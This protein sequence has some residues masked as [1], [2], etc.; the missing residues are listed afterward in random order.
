MNPILPA[1]IF[2]VNGIHVCSYIH[3][4]WHE[5]NNVTFCSN[6]EYNHT[7][8]LASRSYHRH[9]CK[10]LTFLLLSKTIWIIK[11]LF[12]NKVCVHPCLLCLHVQCLHVGISTEMLQYDSC[13]ETRFKTSFFFD[14]ICQKHISCILKKSR[15][16]SRAC[17]SLF[18]TSPLQTRSNE[19]SIQ[20][21]IVTCSKRGT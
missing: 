2:T 18:Y 13:S 4:N 11:V 15:Q 12:L 1:I 17:I 5:F 3:F 21:T 20:I 10:I 6:D 7:R 19:L 14:C 16:K 8:F 9:T